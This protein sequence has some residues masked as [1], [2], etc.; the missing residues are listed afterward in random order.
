MNNVKEI[1]EGILL[2]IF[3]PETNRFVPSPYD[4]LPE[5]GWSFSRTVEFSEEEFDLTKEISDNR[6]YEQYGSYGKYLSKTIFTESYDSYNIWDSNLSPSLIDITVCEY[7]AEEFKSGITFEEM[8]S[9]LAIVRKKRIMPSY[10]I[11]I[12]SR[13]VSGPGERKHDDRV[14]FYL[15]TEEQKSS[16]AA[17]I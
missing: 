2:K 11:K 8:I 3:K 17:R 6:D 7:N 5:N 13:L 1:N 15:L 12:S 10:L 16:L 9:E 14:T 4:S